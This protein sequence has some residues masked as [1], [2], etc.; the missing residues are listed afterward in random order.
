MTHQK[1]IPVNKDG[2]RYSWGE[3]DEPLCT[4]YIKDLNPVEPNKRPSFIRRKIIPRVIK[5]SESDRAPQLT[6]DETCTKV[7][8]FKGYS[9]V[10]ATHGT[11][12][13]KFY[14]EVNIDSMPK[15]SATRIGWG[16]CYANLQAPLGYDHYGYSWRSKFGTKFHQARGKTYDKSGGYK[17]GDTIGCMIDLP[18]GNSRNHIRADHLPVSVKE[19]AVIV[20]LKKKDTKAKLLEEIDKPPSL[21]E[22]KPLVGSK[23]SFFKNG[24]CIGVAFEDIFAGTYYP[25]ISLYKQCIVTVNFGPKFKF[26]PPAFRVVNKI[27][28]DKLEHYPMCQ[29]ISDLGDISI[30]DNLMS[31][32]IYIVSQEVPTPFAENSL[33][34]IIKKTTHQ[35]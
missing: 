1:P 15:D 26:T 35:G 23:I 11:N 18:Y 4:K 8:G 30:I 29:P 22:L 20:P 6:L 34:E 31:D 19:T 13:G 10:R 28:Q 25:T 24:L 21:N 17:E 2:F 7:S 12:R 16:L 33:D 27:T 14:Y 3:D 32:M 9:M 5:L